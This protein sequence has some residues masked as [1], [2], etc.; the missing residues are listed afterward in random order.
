MARGHGVRGCARS[1]PTA[2]WRCSTR[3]SSSRPARTSANRSPPPSSS[4]V[5]CSSARRRYA[6]AATAWRRALV[7]YHDMGNRRGMLN[8]L[9]GVPAWPTAPD[10]P[11]PPRSCSRA[12]APPAT[13]TGF[14][15]PR[16]S[17]TPSTRI[18]EHLQRRPGQRRCG[19]P[20]P[21]SRHRSH[22]RPRARH[23]RRDRRRRAHVSRRVPVQ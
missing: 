13:S 20:G 15:A 4:A 11:R 8:V 3:Q 7:G 22:H 12:C 17:A 18:E 1:I 5:S 14:P 21:A 9:S 6:D 2:R 10:D 23:P 16:T 19:A